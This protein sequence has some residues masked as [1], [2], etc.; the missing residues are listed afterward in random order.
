MEDIRPYRIDEDDD[1]WTIP[2][3]E[4]MEF[5]ASSPDDEVPFHIPRD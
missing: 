4:R 3:D 2:D 1:Q 5:S